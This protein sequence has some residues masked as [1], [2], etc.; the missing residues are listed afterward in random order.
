MS[1]FYK[2]FNHDFN[3]LSHVYDF[4]MGENR[5][6]ARNSPCGWGLPETYFSGLAFKGWYNSHVCVV[7]ARLPFL[8]LLITY[9][10]PVFLLQGSGC[11][12]DHSNSTMG[13]RAYTSCSVHRGAREKAAVHRTLPSAPRCA[14]LFPSVFHFLN[15]L[16]PSFLSIFRHKVLLNIAQAVPLSP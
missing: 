5:Y 6:S 14:V 12:W 7:L 11:T 2:I 10:Q 3:C 8:L 1:L 9:L 13:C 15:F 16:S 4:A